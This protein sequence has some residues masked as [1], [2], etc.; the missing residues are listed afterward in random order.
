MFPPI[1]QKFVSSFYH[2]IVN[3][4]T[5]LVLFLLLTQTQA[6]R[7]LYESRDVETTINDLLAVFLVKQRALDRLKRQTEQ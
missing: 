3:F 2:R 4:S 5:D 6:F 7:S 1:L